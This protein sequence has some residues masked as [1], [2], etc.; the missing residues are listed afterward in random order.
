MGKRAIAVFDFDGTLTQKDT[1][2][3]FIKFV[4][5]K[6]RFYLG[7]LQNAHRLIAYKLGIISNEKAKQSLFSTYFKGIKYS[8]FADN[9]KKFATH[10]NTILK[11]E[12]IHSLQQHISN[13]D[14]VYIVS[15][16]ITEWIE[17]W[18]KQYN[19]NQVIATEIEVS[20][21]G[22]ITGKFASRNC[23][24]QEKV[25]RF[26]LEE[27]N[28]NEYFLYAYGDS[29]GDKEMLKLADIGKLVK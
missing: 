16:S 29:S 9:G 1:L 3:E 27:P 22:Y 13:G 15:A 2:F 28:R 21:E 25:R 23:H 17:P 19:V 20:N 12:Q 5:G 26:L 6:K 24:G 14:K 8:E 11:E 10:I 4:C 18:S 7:I